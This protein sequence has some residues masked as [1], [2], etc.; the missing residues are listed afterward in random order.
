MHFKMQTMLHHTCSARRCCYQQ[1]TAVM[2]AVLATN[3]LLLLRLRLQL[4]LQQRHH[5]VP[6]PS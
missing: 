2:S 5:L 1:L 4:Q 6:Q 3:T